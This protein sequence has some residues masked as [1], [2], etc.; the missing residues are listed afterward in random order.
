MHISKLLF[1]GSCLLSEKTVLYRDAKYIQ[2]ACEYSLLIVVT[3]A[4]KMAF[5]GCFI[6]ASACSTIKI[7]K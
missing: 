7:N 5:L 1:S 2:H 4:S 3:L 6:N